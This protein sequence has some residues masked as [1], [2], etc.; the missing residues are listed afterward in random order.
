MTE[1]IEVTIG[2]RPWLPSEDAVAIAEF[3]RFNFP[4]TGLIRQGSRL[5][6]FDCVDGHAMEG[7][8][9]VYVQVSDQ[10]AETL[11][12]LTGRELIDGVDR[13]FQGRPLMGVLAIGGRVRS[14]APVSE[15]A[16][17]DKGL[18]QALLDELQ[19]GRQ[20]AAKAATDLQHLVS[21]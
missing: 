2:A 1:L 13:A 7:N 8:V 17:A 4:T 19:H 10:G 16:V 20:V 18:G 11:R 9:W 14:G 6:L 12:R 5:Y 21:A 15:Q 3:D